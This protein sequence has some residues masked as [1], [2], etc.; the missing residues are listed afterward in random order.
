MDCLPQIHTIAIH[1]EAGYRSVVPGIGILCESGTVMGSVGGYS[2][3]IGRVS[4]YAVVGK[5]FFERASIRFGVFTG[6]STG[7]DKDIN[8]DPSSQ[9]TPMMGM[10]ISK[11]LNWGP[12][13]ALN[14]V[15]VPQVNG[16]TPAFVQFNFTIAP[17]K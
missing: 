2:N 11:E 12:V 4:D 7:Y 3:S 10:M 6:L 14:L 17:P 15:L 8:G 9:L 5:Y 1:A 16:L 13:H